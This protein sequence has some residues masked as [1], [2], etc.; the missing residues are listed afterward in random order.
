MS[1]TK[2]T[3]KSGFVTIV[4]RP[5]VGK[6]TLM[7]TLIGQK[8]AITSYKPQTTRR[9]MRTVY[10]DERG[11][12]V[13][14]DT[15]GML[16]K[17]GENGDGINTVDAVDYGMAVHDSTGGNISIAGDGTDNTGTGKS[18]VS[19]NA[20]TPEKDPTLKSPGV[21][22]LMRSKLGSFMESSAEET[23]NEVDLVLLLVEPVPRI[24]PADA[25]ILDLFRSGDKEVRGENGQ[26]IAESVKPVKTPVFLVINKIDSVKKDVLLEVIALYSKAYPFAEIY[27][28]S[29]RSKQG[30]PELLDGI[31]RYLPEGEPFYDAD[32]VTDSTERDITAEIIREKA[33]RLLQDEVPHG[34]AVTVES[35]KFRKGRSGKICDIDA[36]II[37]EKDSHKGIIIG[38][39]GEMLRKIG[40]AARVDIENLI[41]CHVNLKLWVKVRKDWRDNDQQLGSF[42][43]RKKK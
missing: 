12:I 19:H 14:V 37:T 5:N 35:M 42:G 38:R 40:T 29:A 34:I 1:E 39:G 18:A 8:L 31:F 6:S 24:A 41:G 23:L 10:T 9:N 30:T 32:T 2:E 22:A 17:Y 16:R 11:Q 27:P 26:I 21:S 28:V 3:R 36:N 33:L 15:P 20:N 7:N 43:Y 13:F 4:G 25:A